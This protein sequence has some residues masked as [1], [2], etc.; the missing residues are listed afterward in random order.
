MRRN[1]MLQIRLTKEER[2]KIE[3]LAAKAGYGNVSSYVRHVTLHRDS[4]LHERLYQ[5]LKHTN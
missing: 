1:H 2:D 4:L 3:D 5:L